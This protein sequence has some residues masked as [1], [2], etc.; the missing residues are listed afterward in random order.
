M[1]KGLLKKHNVG[2]DGIPYQSIIIK[3]L[4]EKAGSEN[5]QEVSTRVKHPQG[6]ECIVG[7]FKKHQF[8][9]I[10][11]RSLRGTRMEKTSLDTAV[12]LWDDG[13]AVLT[14]RSKPEVSIDVVFDTIS[15]EAKL[16]LDWLEENC[17]CTLKD[18]ENRPGTPVHSLIKTMNRISI[19]PLGKVHRPLER[20]NYTDSQLNA[21][22]AIVENFKK[23]DPSGRL[24][25]IDGPPGSG[26]SHFLRGL[27]TEMKDAQFVMIPPSMVGSLGD[28]TFIGAFSEFAESGEPIILVLEDAEQVL[29]T[30]MSDNIEQING[31]LNLTDGMY[32][33]MLNVRILATTNVKKIDLDPAVVRSGRLFRHL[34][35]GHPDEEKKYEIWSRLTSPLTA[36]PDDVKSLADLYAAAHRRSE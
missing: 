15:T 30:R 24:V 13:G 26:K 6:V 19:A 7:F 12:F 34:H 8:R 3:H 16:V 4:L 35:I 33:D 27:I 31:L 18:E 29:A 25:V 5:I 36:L 22:S 11:S 9:V 23:K 1:T 14:F 20:G 17:E 21:F 2:T 32:G 10:E 28:P